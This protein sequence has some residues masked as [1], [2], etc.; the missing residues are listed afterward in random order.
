MMKADHKSE[1]LGTDFNF[2]IHDKKVADI[3]IKTIIIQC[4]GVKHSEISIEI[5]FNGCIVTINRPASQGVPAVEWNKKFQFRPSEGLFE[6]KED[7]ATLDKGYL[8]LVFTATAFQNRSFLFPKHFDLSEY[9][10][11][12]EYD[13]HFSEDVAGNITEPSMPGAAPGQ[14]ESAPGRLEQMEAAAAEFGNNVLE[15]RGYEMAQT[16]ASPI[17]TEDYEATA[18]EVGLAARQHARCPSTRGDS[19][20]IGAF[21]VTAG[22][23]EV[24]SGTDTPDVAG[25]E[26]HTN[27]LESESTSEDFEK[28]EIP[29]EDL[30]LPTEAHM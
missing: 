16:S 3:V 23:P 9:D 4:P 27:A 11:D 26:S 29:A 15:A 28:V 18:R 30:D 17:G 1:D 2:H 7:Q 19:E 10:I 12:R 14:L 20:S 21:E 6:F 24:I 5:I 8:T 25:E 22:S 13:C